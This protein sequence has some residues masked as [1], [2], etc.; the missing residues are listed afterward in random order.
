MSMRGQ[1]ISSEYQKMEWVRD[2]DG[3]EY[4]CYHNDLKEF[5][6]KKG[7]TDEQKKRCLDTSLVAG[8]SW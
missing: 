5:D 6:G 1:I 3:K 8:D 4:A 2:N 7:L